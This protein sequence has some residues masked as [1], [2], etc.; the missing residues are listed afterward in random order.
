MRGGWGVAAAACL[1]FAVGGLAVGQDLCRLAA[2][3]APQSSVTQE[4]FFVALNEV[5]GGCVGGPQATADQVVA[6]LIAKGYLAKDFKFSPSAWVTKGFASQVVYRAFDLRPSLWEWLRI[7]VTGLQPELATTVAQR[8]CVMVL[9][10]SGDLITGRELVALILAWSEFV[11]KNYQFIPCR[12]PAGHT[13]LL[14]TWTACIQRTV[15]SL[16]EAAVYI[17][18]LLE[19]PTS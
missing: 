11:L 9:G 5:L 16:A 3:V 19:V 14:P 6:A 13:V 2:R 1:V 15:M 10:G 17:P 4:D 8:N 18:C 7:A 12:P